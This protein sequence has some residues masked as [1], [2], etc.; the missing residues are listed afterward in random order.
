MRTLKNIL[1]IFILG[2]TL[3]SCSV[4]STQNVVDTKEEDETVVIANDSL[5]YEVIIFDIGFKRYLNT[6]ARP[7]G[8]YSQNYLENWNNIYVTNWN[9]RAQNPT[10]Y[11]PN[12]YANII[13]W[14]PK[15]DYGM[16]VNYKLFNYFQFAQIKYRMRLDTESTNIVRP[17]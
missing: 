8:F 13:N 9:I 11:D 2:I 5:E 3:Y 1:G 10:R 12:L 15:I 7:V 14:D 4:S 16:D 17:R 6:I